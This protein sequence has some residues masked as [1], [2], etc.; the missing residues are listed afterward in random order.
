MQTIT[1]RV[2]EDGNAFR[3]RLQPIELAGRA[4]YVPGRVRNNARIAAHLQYPASCLLSLAPSTDA[5]GFFWCT[6]IMM[7]RSALIA[8][9]S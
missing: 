4:I 2:I 5:T 8:M 1:R 3:L 9:C 6:F 7:A